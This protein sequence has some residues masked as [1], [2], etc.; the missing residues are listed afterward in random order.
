MTV[1]FNPSI[2]N[3]RN[4]AQKQSFCAVNKKWLEAIRIDS[5]GAKNGILNDTYVF[6]KNNKSIVQDLKDTINEAFKQ[7]YI[8]G[9][10]RIKN[11]QK[12]LEDLK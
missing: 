11:Y 3:N 10:N 5:T 1:G 4:K 8:T 9:P 6:N 2:S 12:F 7:G